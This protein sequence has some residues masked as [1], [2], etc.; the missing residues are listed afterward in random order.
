MDSN[1]V[2]VYNSSI[3]DSLSGLILFGLTLVFIFA[4]IGY[5]ARTKKGFSSKW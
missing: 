3:V 4:G 5:Y 1:S 2:E